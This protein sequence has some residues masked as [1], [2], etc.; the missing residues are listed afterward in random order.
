MCLEG[1]VH[2]CEWVRLRSSTSANMT[3][4]VV[5]HIDEELSL[6]FERIAL[7]AAEPGTGELV[8]SRYGSVGSTALTVASSA[9]SSSRQAVSISSVQSLPTISRIVDANARKKIGKSDAATP[10]RT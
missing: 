5:S 2:R 10:L 3:G 8:P 7:I 9:M 1:I 4:R 6:C